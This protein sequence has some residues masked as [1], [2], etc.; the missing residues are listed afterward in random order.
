MVWNKFSDNTNS[1][2]LLQWEHF[3]YIID[4][5]INF[6]K[7]FQKNWSKKGRYWKTLKIYHEF[8]TTVAAEEFNCALCS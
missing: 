1:L 6:R 2:Q 5:S 3:F 8:Q 7:F 4:F